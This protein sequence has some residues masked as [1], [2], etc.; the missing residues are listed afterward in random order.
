M[1]LWCDGAGGG[2]GQCHGQGD[3]TTVSPVTTQQHPVRDSQEGRRRPCIEADN[4]KWLNLKGSNIAVLFLV[5][6]YPI[7]MNVKEQFLLC[8]ALQLILADKVWPEN[9]FSTGC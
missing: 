5:E 1:S 9:N 2:A 8:C 7:L 4:R 6:F 3:M